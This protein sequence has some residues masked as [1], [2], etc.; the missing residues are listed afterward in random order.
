[1]IGDPIYCI[2]CGRPGKVVYSEILD[3]A[4]G[5]ECR[6]EVGLCRWHKAAETRKRHRRST[7]MCPRCSRKAAV[8]DWGTGE[9]LG[10]HGL[11][12][13]TCWASGYS[14]IPC[15]QARSNAV[16]PTAPPPPPGAPSRD[17]HKSA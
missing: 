5:F 2:M 3:K 15:E 17:A 10:F 14:V 13:P 7:L 16:A 1:M 8:A 11:R 12:C 9:L 4:S 6:T